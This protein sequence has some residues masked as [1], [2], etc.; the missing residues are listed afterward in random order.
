[1]TIALFDSF[2]TSSRYFI[3][4]NKLIEKESKHDLDKVYNRESIGYLFFS[5]RE[6]EFKEKY[7]YRN[8]KTGSRNV[9]FSLYKSIN[10]VVFL[11]LQA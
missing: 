5:M 3:A 4:S 7:V 2:Y 1:M 10:S 6:S 11:L 9:N 8:I